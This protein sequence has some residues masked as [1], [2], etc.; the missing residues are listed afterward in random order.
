MPGKRT[1]EA[2]EELGSVRDCS[3]SSRNRYRQLRGT[4][5]SGKERREEDLDPHMGRNTLSFRPERKG[6]RGG[7]ET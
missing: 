3:H 2:R 6:E 4:V 1:R 5:V 7:E